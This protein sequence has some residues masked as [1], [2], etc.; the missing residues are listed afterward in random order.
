M[1]VYDFSCTECGAPTEVFCKLS[2]REDER[3]CKECGGL[4]AQRLTA[5][6]GFR[7]SGGGTYSPGYSHNGKSLEFKRDKP[8]GPNNKKSRAYEKKMDESVSKNY[9][10][11]QNGWK[12][13][14]A[15][16]A[17]THGATAK[18]HNLD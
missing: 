9:G 5:T 3:H 16:R 8:V 10:P 18:R 4:L 11:G 14:D 6:A 2:E 1:P 17:A 7:I 13:Q 15:G 12:A